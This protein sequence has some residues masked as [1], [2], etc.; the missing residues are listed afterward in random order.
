MKT[1]FEIAYIV[2]AMTLVGACVGFIVGVKAGSPLY[3][4]T[5]VQWLN[6]P[7]TL[8]M[9]AFHTTCYTTFDV[10]RDGIEN[11]IQSNFDTMT[12]KE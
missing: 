12:V 11:P 7:D 9:R 8:V 6:M 4:I 1:S 10:W 2:A 5:E 3:E